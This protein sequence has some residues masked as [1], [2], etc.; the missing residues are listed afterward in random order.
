MRRRLMRILWVL[1]L[2]LGSAATAVASASAAV[3]AH[4]ADVD[5]AR[6]DRCEADDLAPWTGD[7]IAACIARWLPSDIL[8]TP[9]APPA[10]E[11][12]ERAAARQA[13]RE[14]TSA[15]VRA[16][17]EQARAAV[18]QP[19]RQLAPI[20]P[21]GCVTEHTGGDGWSQTTIRCV[22]QEVVGSADQRIMIQSQSRTSIA[23]SQSVQGS[24]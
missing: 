8:G 20:Q 24:R 23:V 15:F 6:E 14:A 7:R 18:D 9:D 5:G 3:P 1:G 11:A 16:L 21:P 17:L 2:L 4:P 12:D 19:P 10:R 13:F 22:V